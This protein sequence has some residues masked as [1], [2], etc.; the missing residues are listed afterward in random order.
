[1]TSS[2]FNLMSPTAGPTSTANE[3]PTAPT[4]SKGQIAGI[5]T[6]TAVFIIIAAAMVLMQIRRRYRHI[7]NTVTDERLHRYHG[8]PELPN[9]SAPRVELE[10]TNVALAP[11][12]EG[13]AMYPEMDGQ[14]Q[15]VEAPTHPEALGEETRAELES[16]IVNQG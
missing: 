2:T 5:V 4:L 10:S 14:T 1:M 7:A 8:K 12:L 13:H 15:P 3:T 9:D 6:G 11:E 16:T